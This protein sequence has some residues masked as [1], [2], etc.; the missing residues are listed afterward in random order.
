MLGRTLLA[1]Y[2]AAIGN[3]HRLT[4]SDITLELEHGAFQR[5]RFA[6]QHDG[7]IGRTPH[8]QRANAIRIT[9]RHQAVACNQRSHGIRTL[10]TLVHCT[11]SGK[12]ILSAQRRPLARACQLV[13][14]HVEQ[15]F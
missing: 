2:G 11:H 5:Y 15:H 8:A 10:H 4:W 12:Y 9:K 3:E 1:L 13:R 7:A 14:Q 6:G